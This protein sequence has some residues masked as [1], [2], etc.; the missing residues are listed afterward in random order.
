MDCSKRPAD[1]ATAIVRNTT[2]AAVVIKAPTIETGW[3]RSELDAA[4]R[5]GYFR[6]CM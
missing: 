1:A 3:R 5:P 6:L 4:R 2:A